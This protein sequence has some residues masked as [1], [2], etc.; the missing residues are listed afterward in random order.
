MIINKNPPVFEQTRG[1]DT[2]YASY[3][4]K[5]VYHM[6]NFKQVS[7]NGRRAGNM[8]DGHRPDRRQTRAHRQSD[9]DQWVAAG[10][11][12]RW[13]RDAP[14]RLTYSWTGEF[15]LF[16]VVPDIVTD[17]TGTRAGLIA[18][19]TPANVKI[20]FP[21]GTAPADIAARLN[22]EILAIMRHDAEIDDQPLA[23][24]DDDWIYF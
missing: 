17:D 8:K 14:P 10:F 22:D 18:R 9:E 7:K 6:T 3:I 24:E 5:E 16:E 2:K 21:Y 13:L 23:N 4:Y 1:I 11:F 20:F 15:P 19:Y 12:F